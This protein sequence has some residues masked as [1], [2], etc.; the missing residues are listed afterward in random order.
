MFMGLVALLTYHLPHAASDVVGV[1]GGADGDV[2]RAG[3]V[4]RVSGAAAATI[5]KVKPWL[6]QMRFAS[7]YGIGALGA[8]YFVLGALCFR[9]LKEAQLRKIKERKTMR[10]EMEELYERKQEI[11]RLMS[12]TERNLD[13]L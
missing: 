6:Q 8:F 10:V 11:E 3:V 5:T 2:T 12:E 7:A 1:G 13:R 4:A 9:R